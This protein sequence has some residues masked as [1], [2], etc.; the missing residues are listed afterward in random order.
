MATELDYKRKLLESVIETLQCFNCKDVPG[1]MKDQRNRYSCF[2]KSHQLCENC[3][4]KCECGSLVVKCPNPI[5]KQMLKELPMYCMNYK[6]GCR[7]IFAEPEGL[8]DHEIGC[9]FRLAYCPSSS[10]KIG[11]MVFKDIADHYTSIHCSDLPRSFTPNN[12]KTITVYQTKKEE[13]LNW[14]H[15]VKKIEMNNGSVCFYL[16]TEL[17][18]NGLHSWVYIHGSPHEA[19]NFAYT[20]SMRGNNEKKITYY[21]YVEPLDEKPDDVKAEGLV[22]FIQKKT[23]GKFRIEENEKMKWPF[24]VTIHS[25]KEEAKNED[26]NS[27]FDDETD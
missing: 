4:D 15:W 26:F 11:K 8:N 16:I 2:E 18:Q 20:I 27:G 5:V 1:F 22:F 10:C 12:C 23:V 6:R 19:K 25:L 7:E 14:V 21:D 3:K 9:V 24:E 13:R 17:D